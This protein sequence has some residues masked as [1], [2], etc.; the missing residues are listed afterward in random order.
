MGVD[1]EGWRACSASTPARHTCMPVSFGAW[2]I[3]RSSGMPFPRR[4]NVLPTTLVPIIRRDLVADGLKLTEARWGL[5]PHWKKQAK[6]PDVK[7]S[8]TH[9]RVPRLAS[10]YGLIIV[11]A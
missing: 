6:P 5:I 2:Q 1:G 7:I 3:R 4:Y 8:R 11:A 10:F 9:F